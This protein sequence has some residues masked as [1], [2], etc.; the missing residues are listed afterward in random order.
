VPGILRPR[1]PEHTLLYRVLF[2]NLDR[3]VI[4]YERRLEKECGFSRPAGR[5]R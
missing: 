2:D 5:S 4:E 1:H 3:F